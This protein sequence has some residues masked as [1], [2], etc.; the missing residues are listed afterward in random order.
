MKHKRIVLSEN[1]VASLK[2][3]LLDDRYRAV[4]I[5]KPVT[6]NSPNGNGDVI[7]IEQP[8]DGIKKWSDTGGHWYAETLSNDPTDAIAIDAGHRWHIESGLLE[9]LNRYTAYKFIEQAK[10]EFCFEDVCIDDDADVEKV[11]GGA[12]VQARV[13]IADYMLEEVQ[14]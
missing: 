4:L 5:K 7:A 8:F 12:W 11:E 9:A 2:G 10:E 6:E 1:L 3:K 14:P 13:W